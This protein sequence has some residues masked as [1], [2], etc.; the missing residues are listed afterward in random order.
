MY[1]SEK[2]KIINAWLSM[3]LL[4][5]TTSTTEEEHE[6]YGTSREDTE[7]D[8]NS[9]EDTNEDTEDLDSDEETDI[10]T[11]EIGITD[12]CRFMFVGLSYPSIVPDHRFTASS[13]HDV[14]Y[15][16]SFARLSTSSKAWGPLTTSG[17]WLQIDLGSVVF[18][19]AVA[20]QG[21]G[22]LN[23]EWIESFKIKV[24][25]DNV[26]WDYYQ[27]N[28]INKT[29]TG[30]T[31][32]DHVRTNSLSHPIKAKFIRMCPSTFNSW[33]SLRME[34]YG[35]SSTCS[36]PFGLEAPGVIQDSQMTSSSH[37]DNNHTASHGRL[38]GSSSWCSGN[39]NDTQ[40]IQINLG[41]VM[42]VTGIATQGDHTMDNWVKTYTISYSMD[43]N[44][45][46]T[47][48]AG[49]NNDKMLQGNSDKENVR[50]QWLSHTLTARH[51]RVTPQT[52]NTTICMRLE[53]YGCDYGKYRH[54]ILLYV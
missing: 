31:N 22:A 51:V 14:R 43:G 15:K 10:V 12:S 19:C 39:S 38:Y 2:V 35:I 11:H 32:K 18:V 1:K 27:E 13:Y 42:T 30:N 24:S 4:N 53:L 7:D 26:N 3:Q 52:W 16:P 17:A 48:K 6:E 46:N 21:A 47:Y 20:T 41:K 34:I 54:E 5:T 33:P 40:Y 28:N 36:S 23:D 37:I 8:V 44:L 9:Y 45:W 25:L 50:M 49:G 29:F